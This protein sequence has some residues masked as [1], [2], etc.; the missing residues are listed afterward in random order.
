MMHNNICLVWSFRNRLEFLKRSIE[1]AHKTCPLNVDFCLIDAASNESIIKDL[2]EYVN[3][4]FDRRIRVCESSRRSSLSEAWNLGMMLTDARYI[5]FASSDVEFIDN[6]WI[7]QIIEKINLGYQ[8][9]LIENHAVFCIDK[10]IIPIIGWFDENF[11]P[12]PHFDTDY[13]IRAGEKNIPV[14]GIPNNNYYKHGHDDSEEESQRKNSDFVNTNDRLP[15]NNLNNE[16][17]FK[18]KWKSNWEGWSDGTHPPNHIFQCQRW[19]PEIDP[20][21]IYTR[22]LL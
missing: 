14:L 7:E 18:E 13:M 22:K 9:I 17:Y 21:P 2:R 20:H 5:I 19:L 4:F 11:G 16:N 6:G 3:T 10:K 15:M 12:G 1:T 8:Y